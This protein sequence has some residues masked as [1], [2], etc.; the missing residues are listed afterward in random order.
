MATKKKARKKAAPRKQQPK[1]ADKQDTCFI[2]IA[3]QYAPPLGT[4]PFSL[5]YLAFT[6]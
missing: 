1:E 5:G 6:M 3:I 4:S 2:I